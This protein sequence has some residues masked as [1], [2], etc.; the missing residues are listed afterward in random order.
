MLEG[1]LL[2]SFFNTR[3][4]SPGHVCESFRSV[5]LIL[6]SV[7]FLFFCLC[8]SMYFWR[9]NRYHTFVLLSDLI[10]FFFICFFFFIVTIVFVRQ[11]F[12]AQ[13]I[14]FHESLGKEKYLCWLLWTNIGVR[15]NRKMILWKRFFF[16]CFFFSLFLFLVD[17]NLMKN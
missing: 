5:Q 17:K 14:V 13:F 1:V 9:S 8:V 11:S 3:L 10:K 12:N 6:L 16:S 4:N 15:N 2:F 7:Q